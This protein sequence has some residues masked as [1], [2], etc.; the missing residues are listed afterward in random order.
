MMKKHAFPLVAAAILGCVLIAG[1]SE[2]PSSSASSAKKYKID[3][4]HSSV[5]FRIKHFDVSYFH[6]RFNRIS[7]SLMFDKDNPENCSL[8]A[9][10]RVS[11]LDTNSSSRDRHLKGA[12]FFDAK[13][14]PLLSFKSTAFK[15]AG[16]NSY[17]VSGDLKLHGVTR[18][19]TIALEHTGSGPD[20]WGGFRA[21]FE[22]T[23]TFKRSDFGMDEALR[24]VSDEVR[25][26]ISIE[27]VRQ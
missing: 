25:L 27:T 14:F 4:V 19:I 18:P 5:L 7:G 23:F 21:G 22:T 17:Q 1:M 10:V 2:N 9:I 3:N 13:K 8:E 24:A 20:A 16:S 26:T 11:S 15:K 6:G 12:E